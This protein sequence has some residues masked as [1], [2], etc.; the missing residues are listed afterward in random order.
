VA[1]ETVGR[2]SLALVAE[3]IGDAAIGVVVSERI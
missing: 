1:T 2:I 3:D